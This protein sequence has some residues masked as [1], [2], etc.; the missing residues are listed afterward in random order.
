MGQIASMTALIT[1]V[2]AAFVILFSILWYAAEGIIIIG[3]GILLAVLLDAGARGL[4]HFV[5]WHRQVR[6]II[7]LVLAALLIFGAIWWGGTILVDQ[8][9]LFI[10]A[11]K[12]LV[13]QAE[14]MM[15]Q[16][17]VLFPRGTN[18]IAL[19]PS[20]DEMFGGATTVAYQTIGVVSM[21][22]AI[23]FLGAFFTWEPQ[24]YKAIVLSLLPK[25]KRVRVGEVL[26]MAAG[27]MREWLIGQSISMSV[28]FM[29]SLAALEL[30]GMPYPML[31]AVQAGLLT[32]IPTLGPFIAG[33]VIILAGLSQSFTMALYGLGTYLLIQFLE[34]N[35]VTPL[36]QERTL[37]F[38]PG[39][40]LALQVVSAL[41][42]G[43]LGVAFVVPLAAA[44][45]VLVEELYVK[46]QLGGVWEVEGDRSLLD[47]LMRRARD[48][49]KIRRRARQNKP[50]PHG[51]G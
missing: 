18:P 5:P 45:K 8:A 28:I 50:G 4:G 14:Q 37:R 24:I 43:L 1:A 17:K 13:S 42:F 21:I 22:A 47:G 44:G 46:D 15:Q 49:L 2:V 3:V 40:T 10:A 6:L 32:F 31:L 12:G 35:L 19:L 26:N 33:V 7:V 23:I 16:N 51:S 9:H 41:L 20:V 39:A 25:D 36:V 30:V 27:G 29:F 11:M 48:H 34:S 38:P